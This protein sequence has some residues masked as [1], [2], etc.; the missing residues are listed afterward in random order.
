M[1]F[2]TAANFLELREGELDTD[3]EPPRTLECIRSQTVL[4]LDSGSAQAVY[5]GQLVVGGHFYYVGDDRADKCGAG[6]PG[7]KVA[8]GVRKSSELA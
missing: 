2:L 3:A 8:G 5:D 6:R 7:D 1:K 4:Q